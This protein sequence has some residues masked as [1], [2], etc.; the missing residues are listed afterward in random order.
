[1]MISV[2]SPGIHRRHL[3]KHTLSQK[4]RIGTI[5][6]TFTLI[7]LMA[8]LSLAQMFHANEIS[9]RGYALR[10]LENQKDELSIQNKIL[11]QQVTAAESLLSIQSSEVVKAMV[12]VTNP[13]VLKGDKRVALK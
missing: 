7:S 5:T 10:E 13:I 3:R 4:V 6:L 2:D 8:I 1:M 9:T 12:P 11:R